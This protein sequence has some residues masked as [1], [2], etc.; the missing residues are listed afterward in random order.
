MSSF[1]RQF[2]PNRDFADAIGNPQEGD[3]LPKPS[4]QDA[5]MSVATALGINSIS[6]IESIMHDIEEMIKGDKIYS[7]DGYILCLSR[8]IS[9]KIGW[10]CVNMVFTK[11][12]MPVPSHFKV[13]FG[14]S[15]QSVLPPMM[16]VG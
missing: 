3:G 4:N 5:Q 2:I 15:A 12:S 13:L 9:H 8:I 6:M 10:E 16:K 11:M 14:Q 1:A 7:L